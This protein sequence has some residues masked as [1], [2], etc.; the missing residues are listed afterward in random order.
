MDLKKAAMFA[1][2]VVVV[3]AIAKK[4]PMVKDYV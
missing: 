2:G 1:L 3:V 4:V